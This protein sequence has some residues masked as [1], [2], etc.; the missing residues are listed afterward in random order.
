MG[1]DA[2]WSVGAHPFG[3]VTRGSA[4]SQILLDSV[5][6]CVLATSHLWFSMERSTGVLDADRL[7]KLEP[8]LRCHVD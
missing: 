4:L 2:L 6:R 8:N 1:Q 3:A 7:G 5:H